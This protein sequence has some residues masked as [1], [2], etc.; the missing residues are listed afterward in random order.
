MIARGSQPEGVGSLSPGQSAAP[1]WG[2]S[3]PKGRFH[4]P[5]PKAWGICCTATHRPSGVITRTGRHGAAVG[6]PPLIVA[7]AR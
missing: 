6:S 2:H 7:S 5:R 4:Q 1:P 3:D